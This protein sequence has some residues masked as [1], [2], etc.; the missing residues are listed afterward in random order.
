[1]WSVPE[2]VKKPSGDETRTPILDVPTTQESKKYG[3]LN[4]SSNEQR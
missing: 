1:M 3:S 4:I 2:S